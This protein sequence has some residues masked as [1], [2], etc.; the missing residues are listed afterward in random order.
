MVRSATRKI[1]KL[2]K[3]AYAI[4]MNVNSYRYKTMKKSAKCA[5][6][7]IKKY[8]GVFISK[9]NLKN[10]MNG[11]PKYYHSMPGTIGCYVSQRKLLEK[12]SKEYPKSGEATLVLED[13][14]I[15]PIDFYD[16]LEKVFSEIPKDWDIIYLNRKF[17]TGTKSKPISRSKI[18]ENVFK[19]HN[20]NKD[21]SSGNS[22]YIVKNRT[23]KKRVLPGIKRMKTAINIQYNMISDK[24]NIYAIVPEITLLNNLGGSDRIKIN[25]NKKL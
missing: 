3:D 6:I 14:V 15:F 22:A 12:L 5:G 21:D 25:K 11:V 1:R 20:I 17:K 10:G 7:K 24:A 9:T 2:F 8:P 4:T 18:S 19:I 23:L 13:D 16:K